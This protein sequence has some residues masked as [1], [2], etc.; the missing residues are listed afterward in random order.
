V[1]RL[2]PEKDQ[3]TLLRAVARVIRAEPSFRLEIAGDGPC[4]DDLHRLTGELS[5]AGTARFL[6][7]VRDVPGLLARAGLFV[8]SS[9]SE[10]ISLTLLEAMAS[11][12]P[13]V[14]TRVGGNPEVVLDGQTGW[15]VPPADPDALAAALLELWGNPEAGRQRGAEGRC[16]VEQHFDVRGMVAAYEA[17]YRNVY[18]VYTP[19]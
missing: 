14:A 7:Q 3:A 6:G 2:S 9:L 4:R 8:L 12:L 19:L 15:L 11:G 13:V 5:L 18:T 1:G 16:R 17:M 10:G